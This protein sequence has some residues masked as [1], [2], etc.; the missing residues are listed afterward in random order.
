MAR[1]LGGEGGEVGGGC[2]IEVRSSNG[3][4][5]DVTLEHGRGFLRRR[6]EEGYRCDPSP[7]A[8]NGF[9]GCSSIPDPGDFAV[10]GD[11][12]PEAAL[13]HERDGRR[14]GSATRSSTNGQEV[15]AWWTDAGTQKG[16]D[17]EIGDSAPGTESVGPR[18]DRE[19][20]EG[21]AGI[22]RV[23][24]KSEHEVRKL[25]AGPGVYICD[26]CVELAYKIVSEAGGPLAPQ[27]WWRRVTIG[28][29]SLFE[30]V[31]RLRGSWPD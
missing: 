21:G 2:Y 22:G 16:A 7:P 25:V 11:E 4:V 5:A 6:F 18:H 14:V 17:Q 20:S 23:P 19:R 26:T 30:S 29:R 27:P 12:P 13:L 31:A 8:Q 10:R 1:G 28:V 15:G 24:R 9:A 3:D